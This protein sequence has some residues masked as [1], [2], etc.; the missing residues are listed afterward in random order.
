MRKQHRLTGA[1]R[2]R[3]FRAWVE[4]DRRTQPVRIVEPEA[5]FWREWRTIDGLALFVAAVALLISVYATILTI[6]ALEE[7]Q[8]QTELAQEEVALSRAALERSQV[9]AAWQVLTA[10]APGNSGKVAAIETLHSFGESLQGIDLSCEAMGGVVAEVGSCIGATY[11]LGLNAP[12]IR[13]FSANL[14]SALLT[15]ANLSS[16]RLQVSDFT[17]AKLG[18]VNLSGAALSHADF[19]YASMPGTTLQDA[20]IYQTS[21]AWAELA[22]TNFF[23]ADANYADF[24]SSNLDRANFFQADLQGSNF[25]NAYF[26]HGYDDR[27]GPHYIQV[28]GE[29]LLYDGGGSTTYYPIMIEANVSGVRFC[30]DIELRENHWEARC[31]EGLTQELVDQTWAWEDNPPLFQLR[32]SEGSLDEDGNYVEVDGEIVAELK[33]EAPKLC[34]VELQD[35]YWRNQRFGLPEGC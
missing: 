8:Q 33:L 6:W 12:G 35:D 25:S 19:S 27:M 30:D 11:L 31:A 24:T 2:R 21:F 16:G 22:H 20:I 14:S 32:D 13:M 29:P 10:R 1:S 34:A 28:R 5:P 4:K 7:T 26:G 15:D 17:N 9:V 3:K 23:R 18:L